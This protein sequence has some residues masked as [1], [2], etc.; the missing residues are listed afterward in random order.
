MHHSGENV[1]SRGFARV[2]ERL[3][4]SQRR[5]RYEDT[6]GWKSIELENMYLFYIYLDEE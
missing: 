6:D 2:Q 3:C 4:R 5:G 1:W